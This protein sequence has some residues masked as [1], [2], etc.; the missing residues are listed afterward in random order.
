M[1]LT[2][3]QQ[4]C[5]A[6]MLCRLHNNT[7]NMDTK[8][9]TFYS[10]FI[11][12]EVFTYLWVFGVSLWGGLVSY[13]EKKEPFNWLHLFAHLSSASFAGL[14]TYFVCDYG[15]VPGPLMGVC[16]GVAAHMG[17]PALLRMR[18]FKRILETQF[19]DD[20]P[21]TTRKK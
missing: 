13:F 6:S 7:N 9:T 16:C 15:N 12:S 19:E 14:L 8:Q 11:N 18:I 10:D 5:V 2:H 17:T 1:G 20:K 21:K 3:S 4:Y